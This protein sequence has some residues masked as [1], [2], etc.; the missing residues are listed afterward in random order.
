MTAAELAAAVLP[1]AVTF[2]LALVIAWTHRR[3]YRGTAYTQDYAHTLV[4]I[5]TVTAVLVETVGS[6]LAIGLAMF[7]A[8]SVIRF[9]RN[10]GQSSDLAFVFFAIAVAML[11]ATGNPGTAA[12]VT[13]A[14]CAVALALHH[15]GFFAPAS[16]THLLTLTLAPDADFET[17]LAP[18]LGG[19]AAEHRLLGQRLS[20][21]GSSIELRYALALRPGLPTARFIEALHLACGNRRL[22]LTPAGGETD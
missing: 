18:V 15:G 22:V 16:S 11:A 13:A 3:T 1:V 10:L 14:G 5:A 12:A 17:M 20:P 19:H 6:N 4:I 7:A 8:F 9:P 2:A 21:D